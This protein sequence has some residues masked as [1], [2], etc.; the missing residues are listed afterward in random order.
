MHLVLS[1]AVAAAAAKD[2]W[3]TG[4]SGEEKFWDTW[5]KNRGGHWPGDFKRRMNPD[6]K[7]CATQHLPKSAG[8]PL[9]VLDVGAGP[10]TSCGYR[11]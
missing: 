11:K 3:D 10:I 6:T 1:A 7:F 4:I 2:G 8:A 5:I 9:R